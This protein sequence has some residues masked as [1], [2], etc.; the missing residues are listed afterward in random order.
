MFLNNISQQ[1][2]SYISVTMSY[3]LFMLTDGALRIIILFNFHL[4]GFS[5]LDLAYL[6]LVYELMGIVTNLLA[7]WIA[8]RFGLNITL[9]GGLIIQICALSLLLNLNNFDYTSS[10]LIFTIFV[11]GLSGIAK[12]LVKMSA[13]SS[14]KLIVNENQQ[15]KLFKWV[16][17]LTGSKNAVKELGFF[18]GGPLMSFFN[19]KISI[20]IMTL[21]LIIL[22]LFL[23]LSKPIIQNKKIRNKQ[24][25]LFSKSKKINYLSFSRIFLFGARD[26]WFVVSLPIF[27]Y[28]TLRNFDITDSK[29]FFLVGSFLA[30]WVIFYGI[31]QAFTPKIINI[32]TN[33]V[34]TLIKGSKIWFLRLLFCS[35]IISIISF[36]LN[37]SN[38]YVYF[39]IFGLFLF[40]ILFAVNSSLHSF[41]ILAF[42]NK[43]NVTL[44]VGF[45]YMSNATG[46]FV[47][48]LLSGLTYQYFGI[49][50]ALFCSTIF[51]LVGLFY[52]LKLEN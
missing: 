37:D 29:A 6:F 51:I 21:C 32:S 18:L 35:A 31:T 34:A 10:K 45:Y 22:I 39:L 30:L 28:E 26:I 52:F 40:G 9:Y 33:N 17:T 15:S 4:L 43:I 12:D 13:K 46:R 19:F 7:G 8:A 24:I 1:N 49:V 5:P 50:G 38:Y 47:G 3:W 25:K 41:F 14:V 20:I 11:Y 27:L 42:S 44:D 16:S 36:F 23:M 48:T 2:L